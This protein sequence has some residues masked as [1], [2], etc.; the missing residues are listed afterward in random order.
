[1]LKTV[2]DVCSSGWIGS[3]Q[4][5]IGM[6]RPQPRG[7]R[8]I[9]TS[10]RHGGWPPV[11]RNIFRRRSTARRSSLSYH[12]R[13]DLMADDDGYS[14]GTNSAAGTAAASKPNPWYPD[15]A[16]Y[17][18]TKDKL[19]AIRSS[20]IRPSN[21]F[22]IDRSKSLSGPG[23]AGRVCCVLIWKDKGESARAFGATCVC[24]LA[25]SSSNR[26]RPI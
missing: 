22:P 15:H 12:A 11:L 14:A 19:K 21:A 1:V 7:R 24:Q 18:A 25:V 8:C 23:S 9:R 10:G 26:T 5:T 4:P 20:S 17:D 13:S 2:S 6:A 16:V 3:R